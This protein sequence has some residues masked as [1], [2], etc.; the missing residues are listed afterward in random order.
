MY[1]RRVQ[2]VDQVIGLVK[3]TTLDPVDSLRDLLYEQFQL[4]FLRWIRGTGYPRSLRGA[5]IPPEQY[6]AE[7]KNTLIRARSFVLAMSGIPMIPVDNAHRW[8]VGLQD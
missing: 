1:N 2:S 3:F 6:R 8:T 7:R 4:R 5:F